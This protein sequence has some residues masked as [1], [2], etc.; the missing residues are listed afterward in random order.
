MVIKPEFNFN[1]WSVNN[2]NVHLAD[3]ISV[4]SSELLRPRHLQNAAC[5]TSRC[6]GGSGAD[7]K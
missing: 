6:S 4:S 7:F 1:E 5:V 2:L 3:L